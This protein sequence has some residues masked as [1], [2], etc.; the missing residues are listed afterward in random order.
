MPCLFFTMNSLRSTCVRLAVSHH[1]S[2]TPAITRTAIRWFG[3]RGARGHGW[4]VKYRAG[5]GGRHLQGEYHDRPSMEECEAWNDA[6]LGLGS[7]RVY[8]DLVVEPKRSTAAEGPPNVMTVPP[9]ETLT[10]PVQRLEMDIATTVMAK[11]CHNFVTLMQNQEYNSTLL[12]RFEKQVGLCGG[13]ILTN[14]GKTGRSHRTDRLSVSVKE[15]P[16]PMWHTAGVVSML[17]SAVDEVDSR[18]FFC[19]APSP[20]LDGIHR[21]FGRLTPESL[22]PLQELQSSILTRGGG[23]PTS[24]DLIVVQAGIVSEDQP[25]TVPSSGSDSGGSEDTAAQTTASSTV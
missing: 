9:L 25:Q 12:Y 6:V 20:H 13:D 24:Y 7:T 4:Y 17:V 23:I 14:T 16:L 19:T 22:T 5:E 10:A 15:D 11:T 2:R 18:F 1:G 3:S 21:A 8:M